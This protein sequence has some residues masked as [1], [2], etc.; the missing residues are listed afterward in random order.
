MTKNEFY[1]KWLQTF[2]AD[3][4][5][6]DIKKYVVSTG[7]Y[8]WHIFS[9]EMLNKNMYLSGDDARK[10]YDKIDKRGASYIEWFE[11]DHTKDIIWELNSAQALEEFAEIY[12]VAK[13]FSWSYM[14]THESG[15]GPY[16]IK[17]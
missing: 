15:F 9:W 6:S 14:K 2:A 7:N 3:I 11:D 17:L 5:K 1:Q 8:I 12:V 13:D 16:F 4:P 10:A